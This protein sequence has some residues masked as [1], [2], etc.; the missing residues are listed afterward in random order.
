MSSSDHINGKQRSGLV[1]FLTNTTFFLFRR[2]WSYYKCSLW[3]CFNF[4]LMLM[5]CILF[6][7]DH[8]LDCSNRATGPSTAV[9]AG[10]AVSPAETAAETGWW[11]SSKRRRGDANI[12]VKSS[13]KQRPNLDSP[14]FM[15]I[16]VTCLRFTV[17]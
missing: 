17:L 10:A 7:L 5:S 13:T 9:V 4:L 2:T 14:L 15:V 3:C 1:A 11:R 16:C 6:P 8:L 12:L